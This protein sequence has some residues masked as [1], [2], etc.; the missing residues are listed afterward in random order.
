MFVCGYVLSTEKLSNWNV[1]RKIHDYL[2]PKSYTW[3]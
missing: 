1:I 3:I 2:I